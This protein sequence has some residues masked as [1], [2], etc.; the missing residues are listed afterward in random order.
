[1]ERANQQ[2][3][4]MLRCM[5]SQEPSTW[6]NQLTWVEHA[7]NSLPS[8]PSGLSP[9]QC[10]LGNQPPLFTAQESEVGVPSV[11]AHICRCTRTIVRYSGT[12]TWQADLHRTR[13][14]TEGVAVFPGD[15]SESGFMQTGT[16]LNK[17]FPCCQG[18]LSFVAH[19]KLPLSLHRVHPTFHM[20]QIK[21]FATSSLCSKLSPR[22][23]LIKS[24]EAF[25]V[26]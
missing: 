8:A 1:M 3:E 4:A 6:C 17:T 19:L 2:M 15:P 25:M 16:L 21:P 14:L 26:H 7:I 22:S 12:M 13:V 24:S 9:F 10:S 23:H 5:A 11:E 18:E 20:A